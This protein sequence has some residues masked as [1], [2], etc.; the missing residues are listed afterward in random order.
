MRL[1]LLAFVFACGKFYDWLAGISVVW[2]SECM[3][4]EFL[5]MAGSSTN[6][7]IARYTLTLAELNFSVKWIP[8]LT[9]I[10]DRFSRLVLARCDAAEAVSLPEVVFGL[11]LGKRIHATK[12]GASSM[13]LLLY[14]PTT[15]LVIESPL[16]V[17]VED[18]V[19]G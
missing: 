18:E 17:A 4:H 12:R 11:D 13:P 6:P 10:A 8:G 7:T 2:R 14:A 15:A 16:V 1:E 19:E 9:M 3:A 5:H